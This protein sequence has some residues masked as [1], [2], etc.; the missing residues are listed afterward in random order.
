MRMGEGVEWGVHC[1]AT[2]AW[3]QGEGPVPIRR[4]ATWFD[5]PQEYL[6]KRLQALAR[7]GIL[8]STPGVR[9]GFSLARAPEQITLLD[10]V[11]ALEGPAELFGCSEIRQR[12]AGSLGGDSEFVQPCGV[13]VA[14]RRAEL[15][16][17]REL[18]G[19]TIADLMA[20]APRSGERTL[21]NYRNMTD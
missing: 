14:M 15:A 12:G 21:R 19:Q 10:V 20:L 5:L 9:G 3:L 8:A 7:A 2:L 18:A 13:A 17:R 16:W 1:C 6:K 4:L 11:T